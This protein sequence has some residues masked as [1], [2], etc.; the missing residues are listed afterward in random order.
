MKIR[1]DIAE[2]LHAGHSDRAIGRQLHVCPRQVGAAR[3]LLN[4]PKAKRG[5]RP[6][7]SAED[8]F[9]QRVQP[10]DDGHWVW[11]GHVNNTGCPGFRHGGKFLTAYRVSF[12]MQYDREPE[13]KVT[14]TCNQR[15]CVQHVEDRVIRQRTEATFAAIFG[16]QQ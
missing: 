10:T 9:R 14:P 5:P 2:L 8:L 7:G 13:G 12:R 1:A 6:A 4:L 11:T 15:L 3:A 16:G